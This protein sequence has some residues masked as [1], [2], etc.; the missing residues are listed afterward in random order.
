[1]RVRENRRTTKAAKFRTAE[2][3][4]RERLVRHMF[5]TLEEKGVVVTDEMVHMSHYGF[6]ERIGR[7][8]H[9]HFVVNRFGVFGFTDGP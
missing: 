1:M 2:A 9:I 6:D 5:N 4:G 8:E 3:D 7:D